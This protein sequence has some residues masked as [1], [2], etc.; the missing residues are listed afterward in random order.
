MAK[1]ETLFLQSQTAIIDMNS[2]WVEKYRPINL[3][4]LAA[5]EQIIKFI[6]KAISSGDIVNVI[7]H[8]KP[9]TGKNSIVNILKKNMEAKFLII[10]ASEERGIDTI[11]DKV[12]SFATT[13]AWGNGL[14]IVVLNEA[15]GLNYTAQDSLRELMETASK[16]CRFVFTCNY[17]NK[18][19]DPIKSRCIELELTPKPRE[20]A[21]RLVE[22]YMTENVQFDNNFIPLI[23]KKYGID[24]RKMINESQRI[25]GLYEYL[26]SDNIDNGATERYTEFLDNVFS[27]KSP[28]KI[29]ELSKAMVFD[30]DIYTVL[31]KYILEKYDNADAVLAIGEWSYKSRLMADK[32]L[33]FLCCIFVVQ[34]ICGIK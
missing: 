22:I 26:S 24:I 21:K 12:Q 19:S 29:S 34:D 30:E 25:F 5:S 17:I 32:D 11:R 4:E 28:K 20:I 2:L 8:G 3:S 10:N 13:L 31:W 14:K 18:I 1:N 27:T 7:L 33:S 15:D 6:E 16:T 23:I 9:G